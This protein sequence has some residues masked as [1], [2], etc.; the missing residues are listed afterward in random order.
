MPSN[1][2]Y[3]QNSFRTE[4]NLRQE[5]ENFLDGAFPEISK[6]Q[7]ALLRKM[8]RDDNGD[9]IPCACVDATTGEPDKDT[10]CSYCASEGFYWDEQWLDVYKIVIRSDVGNAGR[11]VLLA[12][13][14]QNIPVVL[15]FARY[16][17]EITTN[18]MIVELKLN[19]NGTVYKPYTRSAI[20][21]I[22][23]L[24]DMRSDNGRLEFW[25][26]ATYAENRKFLNGPNG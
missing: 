22:G 8:R 17:A 13:T 1:D 16:S 23:T 7:K 26:I 12:P 4:V 9:L 11:E 6:K 14:T 15:F 10:W 5:M 3:S 18:D 25:K 21:R 24:Y 2:F 19:T 20:Y